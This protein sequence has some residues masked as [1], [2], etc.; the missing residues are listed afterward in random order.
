MAIFFG[1]ETGTT[2]AL[3]YDVCFDPMAP[4]TLEEQR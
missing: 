3:W 4:G 1:R 2:L